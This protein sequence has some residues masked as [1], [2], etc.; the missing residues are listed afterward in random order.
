MVDT[1][2]LLAWIPASQRSHHESVCCGFP[3][4]GASGRKYMHSPLYRIPHEICT[5]SEPFW[6]DIDQISIR[7]ESVASKSNRYRSDDICFQGVNCSVF[8]CKGGLRGGRNGRA[9]PLN[10]LQ[11]RFFIAILYKGAKDIQYCNK[12]NVI[13][14]IILPPP[15]PPDFFFNFSHAFAPPLT[16]NPG[17]ALVVYHVYI[18]S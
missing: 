13:I 5:C 17:S 12:K 4:S 8:W 6:I 2:S 18:I 1:V 10:F 14:D 9:P 7:D 3:L 16:S 11:I 15:P